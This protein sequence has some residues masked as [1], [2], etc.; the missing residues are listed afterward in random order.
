MF[1]IFFCRW[2]DSNC[3]PLN[4][5]S[6]ALPTEPQSLPSAN[7]CMSLCLFHFHQSTFSHILLG[8]NR[9]CIVYCYAIV[10]SVIARSVTRW[11]NKKSPN[12]SRYCPKCSQIIF[13]WKWY[14]FKYTKL[15]PE[16]LSYFCKKI[17][18]Q[19]VQKIAQSGHTDCLPPCLLW[20]SLWCQKTI[21]CRRGGGRSIISLSIRVITSQV[22]IIIKQETQTDGNN[23]L[24]A[25]WPEGLNKK[26]PN[27]HKNY[28]NDY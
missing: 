24:Q 18:Y 12:F 14:Y 23:H 4:L 3:R 9:S 5:E 7:D 13:R 8:T 6:T 27:A 2:L 17:C 15:L 26:S 28:P 11:W 10:A 22:V 25:G 20:E 1:N 19:D 16:F 21:P